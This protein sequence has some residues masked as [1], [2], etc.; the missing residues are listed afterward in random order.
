MT[1]AASI[2]AHELRLRE[3]IEAGL[4]SFG[5]HLTLHSRAADR[6][7]TLFLTLRDRSPLDVFEHLA[8][9]DVLVPAGTF[10]AHE[11]FRALGLPVDSGLRIGL[12]AYNDDTVAPSS[13]AREAPAYLPRLE[14]GARSARRNDCRDAAVKLLAADRT[15]GNPPDD[16]R[17]SSVTG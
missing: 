17:R 15:Y 13:E 9:R 12:A 14:S 10:Y 7:S 4:A 2:A 5:D 1:A 6:T 11:T 8:K 16:P 3:R